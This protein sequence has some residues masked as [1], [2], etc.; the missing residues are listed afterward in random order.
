M[1]N[2]FLGDILFWK[3]F[4]SG[5]GV[6]IFRPTVCDCVAL[7]IV[8]LPLQRYHQIRNGHLNLNLIDVQ[9]RIYL[10]FHTRERFVPTRSL[11]VFIPCFFYLIPSYPRDF[12]MGSRSVSLLDE[13]AADPLSNP[14]PSPPPSDLRMPF[15]TE[16][17]EGLVRRGIASEAIVTRKVAIHPPLPFL[18]PVV[19]QVRYA[20][21]VANKNVSSLKKACN[22]IGPACA[23][24][25]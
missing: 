10:N 14:H 18:P 2:T 19:V 3:F 20:F 13:C 4:P 9:V 21:A 5:Q 23:Y 25:V 1:G 22:F 17:W 7:C 11:G 6:H 15:T 12:P 24:F 8:V 16:E